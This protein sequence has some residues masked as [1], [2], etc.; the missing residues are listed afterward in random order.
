M[1]TPEKAQ[2]TDK[3]AHSVVSFYY[4]STMAGEKVE[5]VSRRQLTKLQKAEST[6]TTT[7]KTQSQTF[8]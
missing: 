8:Q 4:Q 6:K 2:V 5:M 7:K 3:N 1:C